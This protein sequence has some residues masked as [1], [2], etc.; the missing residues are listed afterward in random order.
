MKGIALTTS[1]LL[2]LASA[3]GCEPS[4]IGPRRDGG[5][6][7]EP[8]GGFIGGCEDTIDSDGD[9]I[10]DAREGVGD[11]DMDGVPNQ[12]DDDS[13]GDGI[14]DAVEA[15]PGG[16]PCAPADSDLDGVPDFLDLDSDNDGLPDAD[17]VAAGTDPRNIDSDGDGLTDL[18]EGAA[19]TDP[20]DPSSTIP[21]TDFFVVLPYNGDHQM[22]PLRFGTNINQADVFF[23]VDMTGSMG[24]ER[25]NLIN[26]LVSVIIPGIQAEIRDVQFGAGGF[27]DYPVGSFGSSSSNDLPFYLLRSIAPGDE[28]VGAWSISAGPTT[29]PRN[30][31]TRDIGTI[32]GGPNGRPDILEAVEGLPCHFGGDD[33]ESYVPALWATATGGGLNWPNDTTTGGPVPPRTC[34][35]IPDE[36]GVRRG[37]PCFRPGSLP[38]IL[39]FGDN[40]FHNG[41]GGSNSY[42]FPA[43]TYA[44]AVGALNDIGAR[45]IGIFSGGSGSSARRDYEAIA[46]DTG[47]VRADGTPLV[48]NINSNG[49]GLDTTVVEAV[50][51]LVGGT[52]QDVSTTTENVPGNPDD[53][54]ARLFIKSI[55]P[56]EGYNGSV[57][58]PMPGVTYASK[59]ETTFYQVIPG[60]EVEFTVDFWNDVRMPAATAQVFRATIVVLGNGVARLDERRVF[61]VVP[62]D[63]GIVLI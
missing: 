46:R 52:P 47:A 32:T 61:I 17:E 13:D 43:P 49:T 19:G 23:L 62:P 35:T 60:T 24:G 39:L 27:D 10:A 42:S 14:P 22:R 34:P 26:G 16:N 33:P 41:P 45:V 58:G 5:G 9:G 3:A 54:D 25:T 50:R 57:S 6:A 40:T 28:D 53:F 21:P 18:A 51:D 30:T 7:F 59:D 11:P 37:Y 56:L 2:L 55:V 48:F 36:V 20:N 29:C 4:R 44:Q 1:A 31:A 63:G 15:G 8:D 38:I 12:H